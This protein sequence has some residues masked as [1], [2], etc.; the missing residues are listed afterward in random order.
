MP[1][2]EVEADVYQRRKFIVEIDDDCNHKE[3]VRQSMEIGFPDWVSDDESD[4]VPYSLGFEIIS[5]KRIGDK[6]AKI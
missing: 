6:D 3:L 2:Y 1:K 5:M 4:C